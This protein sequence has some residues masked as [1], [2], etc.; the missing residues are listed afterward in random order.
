MYIAVWLVIA[1]EHYSSGLA[2]ANTVWSLSPSG[3]VRE[4]SGYKPIFKER[5]GLYFYPMVT[6]DL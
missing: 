4:L 2:A 6:D 3:S 5:I 1:N